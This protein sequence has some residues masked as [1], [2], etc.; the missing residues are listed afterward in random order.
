MHSAG[1]GHACQLSYV[2]S[3]GARGMHGSYWRTR[4]CKRW[5]T[6]GLHRAT[7]KLG[8]ELK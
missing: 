7:R 1:F 5:K 8:I 2:A 3:G 4:G 6:E